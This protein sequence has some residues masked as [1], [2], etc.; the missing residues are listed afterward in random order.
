MKKL[1]NN[2]LSLLLAGIVGFG[3]GMLSQ[4]LNQND[5]KSIPPTPFI[6]NDTNYVTTNT[7]KSLSDLFSSSTSTIIDVAASA[8]PSVVEIVTESVSTGMFMQQYIAEGAGSGVILS[9]DG[10]IVTNNHV[11]EGARKIQV[12]LNDGKAFDAT[13]IGSDTQSD[14]AVIKIDA[15]GLTP[16]IFSDSSTLVVGQT[17]IAIG[18][19]L[20]QLGGTVTDGIISALHREITIDNETMT[21]LQTN[22]AI[23]PGNSGGGLFNAKGELIGIVNAKSSGSGIEGLG[24]AIP[25]NYAK[26]IINDIMSYG[27][28]R[29][30]IDT[31]LSFIDVTSPQSAWMYRVS[32]LGIYISKV[33]EDSN[34]YKSGLRSGDLVIAVDSAAVTSATD[35]HKKVKSKSVGDNITFTVFRNQI[36]QDFSFVLTE[37]NPT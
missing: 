10:N 14:I 22:A 1:L 13:L 30:R 21:L 34:A 23:N 5:I 18:N 37:Y 11:I 24:F 6:Q 4:N 29:G 19:P 20:G 31:G 7:G 25:I 33:T 8:A 35:I 36:K 9:S 26:V 15:T 16:A 17:A 28:A 2:L 3:G 12:T 27:Y 32:Y